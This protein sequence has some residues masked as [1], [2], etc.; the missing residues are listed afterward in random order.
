[1]PHALLTLSVLPSARPIKPLVPLKSSLPPL[2]LVI[3]NE[4]KVEGFPQT[5][6][7]CVCCWIYECSDVCLIWS[8]K[9]KMQPH[10]KLTVFHHMRLIIILTARLVAAQ[11]AA[12]RSLIM[13]NSSS[14]MDMGTLEGTGVNPLNTKTFT[15]KLQSS[16][17]RKTRRSKHIR[18]QILMA[19]FETKLEFHLSSYIRSLYMYIKKHKLYSVVWPNKICIFYWPPPCLYTEVLTQLK[20]IRSIENRPLWGLNV[21]VSFIIQWAIHTCFDV[22]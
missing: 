10:R 6:I 5:R 1:M 15:G 11:S 8:L 7:V 19:P 13:F 12:I 16:A 14:C 9:S 21:V 18:L 20:Q 4:N 2:T 3:G 17:E 22:T